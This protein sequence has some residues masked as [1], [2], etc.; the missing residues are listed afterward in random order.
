MN[1]WI[2]NM[3][4]FG[5][6]ALLG[7]ATP[8]SG[9]P[10]WPPG[11][12]TG[13]LDGVVVQFQTVGDNNPNPLATG[14]VKGRTLTHEV[15][16]YLGLRHIW[17][18]GNC[19]EEDGIDDTPN[20]DAQSNQ[21]CDTTKNT[22]VDN[23]FG[24]DLPDMVENYMDYSAESCQNSFTQGQADLMRAVLEN[25][26]IDLIQNN[27]ASTDEAIKQM[28]LVLYPNPTKD[29][30]NITIKNSIAT[31]INVSSLDGKQLQTIPVENDQATLDISD[32]TAGVF[33]VQIVNGK[34]TI[35]VRRIVK[36]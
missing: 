27:P 31:N 9:L 6:T 4:I 1:V 7:Y 3:E 14:D 20:A 36:M 10:N 12:T 23:I 8:P 24:I 34:Q 22:C 19:L 30:V 17:G 25:Q 29:I 18:D 28:E 35:A 21:D 26:R 13:L 2:C 5:F 32:L 11:A 33:L 15:G 16:H